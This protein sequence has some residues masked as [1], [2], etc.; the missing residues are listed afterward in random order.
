[1][2]K[3]KGEKFTVSVPVDNP[4]NLRVF[5]ETCREYLD[6]CLELFN[7]HP[8]QSL[9]ENDPSTKR[10]I[11]TMSEFFSRLPCGVKNDL[12]SRARL[13]YKRPYVEDRDE[14]L[15]R[16]GLLLRHNTGGLVSHD[17]RVHSSRWAYG[18]RLPPFVGSYDR[19]NSI[20]IRELKQG[21]LECEIWMKNDK[22][23][24]KKYNTKP[25]VR[26]P[27]GSFL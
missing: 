10:E 12:V 14:F 25:S 16:E 21:M 19:V 4:A 18:F 27:K 23:K 26:H 5:L 3:F 22:P 2:R 20:L 24:T 17:R 11:D 6:K 7:Q 15:K 9:R 8:Q 13:L 1:M